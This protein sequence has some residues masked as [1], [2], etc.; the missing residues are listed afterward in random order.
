MAT[1]KTNVPGVMTPILS[2]VPEDGTQI[3][4]LNRVARGDEVGIPVIAQLKDS[5]GDY[6]PDDTSLVFKFERPGDDDANFTVSQGDALAT[7]RD[8]LSVPVDREYDTVVAGVGAPKDANLYQS[9][10]AAT[11]VA[12]G[13]R[14]P[15]APGGDIV[16]PARLPE[17][18][19]EGAGERRFYERLSTATDAETL[20]E[21]MRAGYEPGAQRAFVVARVLREYDV[22]VTNSQHPELVADCLFEAADRP[23]DAIE[24]GSDVLVVPD[25]LNTLLA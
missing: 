24:P 4:L 12:L 25:A 13:D 19:G 22:W 7:A 3:Q 20:Y 14:D 17:G 15:L 23:E 18:A 2:I 5:A 9:T 8:A 10:R 6:L 21:E 11:Y 1:E 16:V